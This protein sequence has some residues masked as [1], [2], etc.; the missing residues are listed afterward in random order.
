MASSRRNTRSS[1]QAPLD[2][3]EPLAAP[4]HVPVEHREGQLLLA[5]E[6]VEEGARRHAGR[7]QDLFQ[8]RGVVALQGKQP[9]RLRQEPLPRCQRPGLLEDPHPASPI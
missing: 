6:V 9:G 7:L 3:V 2:L 5:T 8:L 1:R 4:L